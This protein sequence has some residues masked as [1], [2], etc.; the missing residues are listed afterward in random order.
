MFYEVNYLNIYFFITIFD[1]LNL[2]YLFVLIKDLNMIIE[3]LIKVIYF[4]T[5]IFK[6]ISLSKVF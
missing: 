2:L 3:L 6:F 1:M 5:I 4:E